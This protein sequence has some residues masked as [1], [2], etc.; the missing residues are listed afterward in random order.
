MFEYNKYNIFKKDENSENPK[1]VINFFGNTFVMKFS[2][3]DSSV[4]K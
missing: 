3:L 4:F 1:R 2:T